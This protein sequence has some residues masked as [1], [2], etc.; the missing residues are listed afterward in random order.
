MDISKSLVAILDSQ[1]KMYLWRD[2]MA[3]EDPRTKKPKCLI[4]EPVSNSN[5]IFLNPKGIKQIH[6]G[7]NFLLALGRNITT[8]SKSKGREAESFVIDQPLQPLQE[9]DPNTEGVQAIDQQNFA[10]SQQQL[11]NFQMVHPENMMNYYH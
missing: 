11:S 4:E 8:K 7:H 9:R 3:R 2:Q 1:K 5:F 6:C 10:L